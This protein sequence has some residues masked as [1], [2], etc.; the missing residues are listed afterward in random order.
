MKSRITTAVEGSEPRGET[1][2]TPMEVV[3]KDMK[4]VGVRHEDA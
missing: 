1:Q 3:R 2:K 4:E